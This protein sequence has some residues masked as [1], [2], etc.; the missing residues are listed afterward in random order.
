MH[1]THNTSNCHKYERDGTGKNNLGKGARGSTATDEK[2]TNAYVQL[3]V[4]ITTLG[5]Q[6]S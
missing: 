6:E 5:K 2:S 3:S 4:K 1:V